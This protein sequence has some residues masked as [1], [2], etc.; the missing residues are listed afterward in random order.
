MNYL[1]YA[2]VAVGAYFLFFRQSGSS[3]PSSPSKLVA[4]DAPSKTV[5]GLI[6]GTVASKLGPVSPT[7][8]TG[9][10]IADAKVYNVDVDPAAISA[11]SGAPTQ[12]TGR[13]SAAA[14]PGTSYEDLRTRSTEPIYGAGLPPSPLRNRLG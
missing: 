6:P 2:A 7:Q 4:P 13:G 12:S 14:G 11:L 8:Q 9:L 5:G 1:I 10:T 3:S